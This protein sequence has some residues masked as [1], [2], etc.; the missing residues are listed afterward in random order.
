MG[1]YKIR[2]NEPYSMLFNVEAKFTLITTN[3][4]L[5]PA[6]YNLVL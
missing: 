1:K 6:D 4:R 3:V 2:L 5:I